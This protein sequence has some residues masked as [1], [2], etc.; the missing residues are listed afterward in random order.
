MRVLAAAALVAALAALAPRPIAAAPKA[1]AAAG[2]CRRGMVSIAGRFCVDPFEE[3]TEEA[4]S[5]GKWRAH[6]PFVPVTGLDVRAVSRK[7]VFPQ[8]YLSRDDAD[9]ACT[10]AGKRLCSD[11]EWRSACKGS[12]DAKF[13]WGDER[14][15]GYCADTHRVAP[16]PVVFP[17]VAAPLLYDFDRMNDPRLNQVKGSLAPTGTYPRCRGDARVWDMV[18]NLHEWTAATTG[19][20]RGGYYLDT[21]LN[22][23]GCDYATVAHDRGY[24]DYSIGFRCCADVR[25]VKR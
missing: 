23:D 14:H 5:R 17:G 3:S 6:S 1:P 4:V 18:G 19:T 8:A 15:D 25:A 11:D 22:G 2:P 7:G 16:L 13:P 12:R 20:F 9:A 21:T 24:H 10:R